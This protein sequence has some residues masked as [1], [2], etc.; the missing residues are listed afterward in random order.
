M[1]MLF[2]EDCEFERQKRSQERRFF[3]E[4]MTKE[5]NLLKESHKR[6]NS[7]KKGV[8]NEA[9]MHIQNSIPTPFLNKHSPWPSHNQAMPMSSSKLVAPPPVSKK[10][11]DLKPL[12]GK[13]IPPTPEEMAK[14]LSAFGNVLA[15]VRFYPHNV[16][17]S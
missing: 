10:I 16:V 2:R 6:L 5:E 17:L 11:A 4:K 12:G 8:P 14:Q 13:P 3:E 7:K 9:S 1:L 15:T